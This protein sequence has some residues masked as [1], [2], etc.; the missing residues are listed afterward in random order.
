MEAH[1]GYRLIRSNTS[2]LFVM[3]LCPL[4]LNLSP[5]AKLTENQPKKNT[6]F[7]EHLYR[8]KVIND[9]KVKVLLMQPKTAAKNR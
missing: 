1:F 7:Q 6:R 4:A 5:L 3:F 8:L 9:P 2:L